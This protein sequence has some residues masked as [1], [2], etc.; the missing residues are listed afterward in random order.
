MNKNPMLEIYLITL[1]LSFNSC[2]GVGERKYTPKE[3]LNHIVIQ[4]ENYSKDSVEIIRQLQN[5]LKRHDDFFY[6]KAYFEGTQI[7]IDSIIYSPDFNKLA[8]FVITK[9][10]T[11]R[12]LLPDKK[13]DWYYD[14]TCY[15]GLRQNDTICLS[16][17][18]PNFSNSPNKKELSI[19]MRETY[20]TTY[21]TFKDTSG[22]YRYK[23]NIDDIRFWDC[24][25]WN[26]IEDEK[27]KKQEFEEEKRKHPEN[28]YEPKQ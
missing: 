13:H 26:E 3:F 24:P 4:K 7:I 18:G 1:F 25:I 28:V 9:N 23:Y 5:F 15:L 17:I 12:Q 20:F 19:M 14:G 6:S 10:P 11:S 21:A 27:I 16:R 8:V 22:A 2:E